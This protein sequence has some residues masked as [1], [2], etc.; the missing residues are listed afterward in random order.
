MKITIAVM[1]DRVMMRRRAAS[2][3]ASVRPPN[4]PRL[5]VSWV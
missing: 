4:A 2:N 5:A 1:I 3:A